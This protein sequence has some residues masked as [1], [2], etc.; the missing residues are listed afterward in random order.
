MAPI[1]DILVLRKV[2]RGATIERCEFSDKENCYRRIYVRLNRW[3]DRRWTLLDSI[4][5]LQPLPRS[6]EKTRYTMY[7]PSSQNFCEIY[8][9]LVT[10]LE[11][12]YVLGPQLQY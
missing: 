10:N 5:S 1:A 8:E 7:A 12:S 9:Y 11:P 6:F 3:T 2:V 4:R